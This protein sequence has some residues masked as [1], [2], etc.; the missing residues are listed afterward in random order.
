VAAAGVPGFWRGYFAAR[1][2]PLGPVAPEVVTALFFGFH[3]ATVA[4]AVPD[5]WTRAAPH[6]I[7][8]AR[9]VGS[10]AALDRLAGPAVDPAVVAAA[11]DAIVAAAGR[12]DTAGRALAAANQAVPV[13]PSGPAWERLW[14]GC[15]TLREHRGDGH[16]AALVAAGCN[17]LD[18][19]VLQVA[20]E[21]VPRDVIL[22][23]RGWSDEDWQ[24]STGRLQDRGLVDGT[25]R[26]TAEGRALKDRIEARTDE[27]AGAGFT[28]AALDGLTARCAP[29]AAALDA[30]AY[31]RFP[32]PMGLPPPEASEGTEPGSGL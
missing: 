24:A 2:A 31:M 23:A 18:G 12:V 26:A 20:T 3:P 6:R 9:R 29:I 11:A 17:G 4:R 15:T 10:A 27:L 8:E 28:A 21:P 13:D 16:V 1:A 22:P 30:A 14:Q 25:G 5:V 7:V 32:N 19:H